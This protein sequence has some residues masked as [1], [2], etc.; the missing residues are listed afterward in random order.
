M[1]I[2]RILADRDLLQVECGHSERNEES[3]MIIRK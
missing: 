3:L 1:R 2:Q